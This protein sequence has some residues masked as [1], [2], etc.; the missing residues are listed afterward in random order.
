M[1]RS[2]AIDP[3]AAS[4]RPVS[5]EIGLAIPLCLAGLL[6]FRLVVG[7][8]RCEAGELRLQHVL[9]LDQSILDMSAV[10]T[11]LRQA[12][13]MASHCQPL[14]QALQEISGECRGVEV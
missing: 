1:W 4:S 7:E 2:R 14:A 13:L 12:R 9:D 8:R 6:R 5:L 10:A 11:A 3:A